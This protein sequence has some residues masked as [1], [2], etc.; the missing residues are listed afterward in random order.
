[1]YTD[2]KRYPRDQPVVHKQKGRSCKCRI[3][4]ACVQH[5]AFEGMQRGF[6]IET[7]GEWVLDERVNRSC[8]HRYRVLARSEQ[9]PLVAVYASTW[10]CAFHTSAEFVSSV[11]IARNFAQ[12]ALRRFFHGQAGKVGVAASRNHHLVASFEGHQLLTGFG[13]GSGV[14]KN[15]EGAVVLHD[16]LPK[17]DDTNA[18]TQARATKRN[19]EGGFATARIPRV[20]ACPGGFAT[21]TATAMNPTTTARSEGEGEGEGEGERAGDKQRLRLDPIWSEVSQ[22]MR[23]H[24]DRPLEIFQAI[25]QA[26]SV[27]ALIRLVPVP[28]PLASLRSL[29]LAL[30]CSRRSLWR[31]TG[32]P[33]GGARIV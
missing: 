2:Y 20:V 9:G 19:V 17:P 4:T 16:L 33:R 13:S 25:D 23:R 7:D 24:G 30:S 27:G 1:M 26:Y 11:A 15:S 21:A 14:A 18:A 12:Q 6:L 8:R 22:Y 5:E 28:V 29:S 32:V 3:D 10:G 31:L